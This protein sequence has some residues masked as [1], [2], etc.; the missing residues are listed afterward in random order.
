VKGIVNYIEGLQ[1]IWD[2]L[3]TCFDRQEKHIL[4]ALDPIVK[5]KEYRALDSGAV[6]ELYSLLRSAMLQTRK[7]GLLH[8][9]VNNQTLPS[10]LAWMPMGDWKQWAKER[11]TWIDG[12]VEDA[13]WT[14]VDQK[15][16]DSLNVAAAEPA[17]WDQGGNNSR[18]VGFARKE[19]QDKQGVKKAPAAGVHVALAG[20]SQ[21]TSG[22]AQKRCKFTDVAGF[23]GSHSPW[24]CRAF[25]DKAPEERSKTIKDNKLCPF[26]LL[27]DADEVL[28]LPKST[29]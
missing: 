10:I 13:F 19:E 27:H 26:C 24:L 23:T 21:V 25:G 17:W 12:P 18:G 4:E 15:W 11:P 20:G 22:R 6:K 5:F 9:L 2:T 29:K 3:D 8:H 7:L 1:E 14:F 16:K 28:L